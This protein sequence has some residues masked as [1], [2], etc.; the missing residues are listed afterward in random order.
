MFTNHLESL[1]QI[2]FQDVEREMMSFQRFPLGENTS[3]PAFQ[4]D[5]K[6]LAY[7]IDFKMNPGGRLESR[8]RFKAHT[9]VAAAAAIYDIV[10]ANIGGTDYVII[11]AGTKIYY[12]N[13]S[14]VPTEIGTVAGPSKLIPYNNTCLI[15]D[16]GYLK[17]IKSIT[18]IDLAY[19]DGDYDGAIYN[20]ATGYQDDS[21]TESVG[22]V[23]RVAAKF[24]TPNYGTGITMPPTR[25]AVV[26]QETTTADITIK[27]RKVSDDS[28]VATKDYDRPISSSA[29]EEIEVTFDAG[30]ITAEL[31]ASTDYYV[32]VEGDG[33]KVFQSTVVSGGV[34][35]TY[36]GSTW[37]NTAT[38]D[39]CITVWPGLP[40]KAEDGIIFNDSPFIKDPDEPGRLYFGNQTHLDWSTTNEAGWLGVLDEGKNS[41]PVGA[42][43]VLYDSLVI[44]GT[45]EHPFVAML[46]GYDPSDYQITS[47]FQSLWST[48][49]L[50]Q[51]TNNEF[52]CGSQDGVTTL[53]GVEEYGDL[54]TQPVSD[55][56]K[57]AFE[58]WSSSAI[59]GYYPYDGQYW[60]FF[61]DA[62]TYIHVCH[63]K[64]P[65]RDNDGIVRFPWVRYK[66]V[67]PS[68]AEPT[69][70]CMVEGE[71]MIGASDG[72]IYT[73]SDSI[74]KD[75]TTTYVQPKFKTAYM[76][77]VFQEA[78]I[79]QIQTL[80]A[81]RTGLEF[82]LNVY[83][84]RS[85]RTVYSAFTRSYP[86]ADDL[87]IA[88]VED[89]PI[90]DIAD[91]A[92]IEGGSPAFFDV[93]IHC[94]AIQFE[95]QDFKVIGTPIYV[96]GFVIKLRK[97]KE[98]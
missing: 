38:A 85:R 48:P 62:P 65:I 15:C 26:V 60:L 27:I 93:N 31:A 24:T 28:V 29:P 33:F 19:D 84:N 53:S 16:G 41:Y 86:L 13:G 69:K 10:S 91:R 55:S 73:L 18:E 78:D 17:Y 70:F 30:D 61:P 11:S 96:D 6:E 71:F 66:N 54:R 83:V 43:G 50:V 7:C 92:V 58:N 8:P 52:W 20:N 68:S 57:D 14:L 90:S 44:I 35:Y 95:C 89:I 9:T 88:E 98:H 75:L 22:G 21:T 59:S 2:P 82:T 47:M 56:I 34:L 97:L 67:L 81:C 37:T 51:N 23:E 79:E 1:A 40:P 39:P 72:K 94:F 45:E 25:V 46:T 63:V 32:S 42:L 5:P 64:Q 4:L 77:T 76:E 36:D 3:V 74:I 12:L 80:F 87:T 49:G